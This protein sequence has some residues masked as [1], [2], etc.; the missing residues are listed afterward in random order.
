M[1]PAA[2]VT[3]WTTAVGLSVMK[4]E[5]YDVITATG[6]AW[7]RNDKG[8]NFEIPY[9]VQ[10]SKGRIP[11]IGELWYVDRTLGPWTFAAYISP[12]DADF[13][14]FDNG[15]AI[16]TNQQVNVGSS[17]SDASFASVRAN[18]AQ[19]AI[20]VRKTGD[21][22]DRVYVR[23]DGTIWLGPGNAAVDTYISRT[24]VG[25][26]ATSP[27][28][29]VGS[30]ISSSTSHFAVAGAS[31]SEVNMAVQ[32]AGETFSRLIVYS[33]GKIGWGTGAADRDTWLYRNG[34]GVLKTDGDLVVA[35]KVT[36]GNLAA[37]TVSIT[38][39]VNTPTSTAVS[40]FSVT[41]S[42]SCQVTA[43]TT[44]PGSAVQ[45]VSYSGLSSTGVTIWIYRGTTTSTVISWLVLG[46]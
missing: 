18:D 39:V 15:I 13:K 30:T 6:I 1:K 31:T 20:S 5:V 22:V 12:T 33:D 28:L 42:L 23:T 43:N 32:V 27:Y 9:R 25:M 34:A 17:T 16:P 36:M 7:V 26:L 37:G 40:G 2:P 19:A 4:V 8:Q 46:T 44:V 41:G 3:G 45:E 35:G 14:L 29:R 24:G 11:K 21:T 38:P 10:R